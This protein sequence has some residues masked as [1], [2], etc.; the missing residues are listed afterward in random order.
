MS[1]LLLQEKR[2]STA[3]AAAT[4]NLLFQGIL[5]NIAFEN[6]EGKGQNV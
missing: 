1:I 5:R 4:S 2:L 3:K 6:C